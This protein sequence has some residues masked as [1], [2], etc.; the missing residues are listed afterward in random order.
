MSL[1]TERAIPNHE[2]KIS[3]P[4]C[5]SQF[6]SSAS[7]RHGLIFPWWITLHLSTLKLVWP[8]FGTQS[9]LWGLSVVPHHAHG[10][11]L[12]KGS[13]LH[14]QTQFAVYIWPV[15][16]YSLSHA[17]HLNK[18]SISQMST[19]SRYM[20]FNTSTESA[21]DLG[22]NFV[23][24]LNCGTRFIL[25]SN[26]LLLTASRMHADFFLFE[27]L[28]LNTPSYLPCPFH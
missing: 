14:V 9:F 20:Q 7:W 3:L 25:A 12:P 15:I 4:S 16:F 8:L 2:S 26:T 10:T 21:G 17:L 24:F 11:W 6:L 1:H 19:I 13:W 22:H 18:L 28:L 27:L 23:F 5:N